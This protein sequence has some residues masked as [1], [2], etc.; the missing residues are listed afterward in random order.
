VTAPSVRAFAAAAALAMAVPAFAQPSRGTLEVSGGAAIV[1]G[2]DLGDATAE[3]TSNTGTTGSP[4]TYFR[5]SNTVDLGTGLV[6]RIG[7]YVTPSLAIEGGLRFAQPRF[8]SRITDDTESAQD[9]TAEETLHQYVFEG[10]AVWHFRPSSRSG[11]V[12]FVSGG[13]GYL[14]ELHEGDALVEE[15]T[16]YHAGGG[17]KWW[18][19]TRGR[20]GVRAEAGMS[21]RDG[22][23][24]FEEKRR[25]VP[26]AAGS[27]MWA[28]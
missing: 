13:A 22:G 6:G 21:I 2:Y 23:F 25:L 15:G 19:G 26:F 28:F 14:R 1:G 12:P 16:E 10:S 3:L 17:I 8:K 27:F 11:V 4:F 20:M 24:D 18:L 5:T 7:I 9:I